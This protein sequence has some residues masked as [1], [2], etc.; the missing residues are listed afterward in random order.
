MREYKRFFI[1]ILIMTGVALIVGATAIGVLYQTA[2]EE[3]RFRLL[4]TAQ[5]QARLMEAVARFDRAYNVYPEGANAATLLQIRDAHEHFSHLGMGK[6]GEFTL[7][8]HE[9]NSIVFLLR[10]RHSELDRPEPVSFDSQRAG[11]RRS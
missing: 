7:A 2:L 9:G 8:R 6:T 3:A 5:S 4:E 11:Q 1:L 10:H